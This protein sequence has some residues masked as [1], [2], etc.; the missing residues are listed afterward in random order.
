[1]ERESTSKPEEKIVK[2]THTEQQ[3][4]KKWEKMKMRDLK[5]TSSRVIFTLW[6]SQRRAREKMSI[7]KN[8][9]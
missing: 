9:V 2:L 7:W 8:N 6:E 5:T 4:G 3:K 1:M